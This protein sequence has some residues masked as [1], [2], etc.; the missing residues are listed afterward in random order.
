MEI[1]FRNG[2][3]GLEEYK[4]FIVETDEELQPFNILQSKDKKE[5]GLVVISPFEVMPDYEI[6]LSESVLKNL[7]ISSPDD[8]TLYTT[9]TLNS[10]VEKITANLR[11]PIVVNMKSGLGEQIIVDNDKYKI[12]HPIR[13]GGK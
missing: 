5:L 12:K 1:L 3:P 7:K 8:V 6:K 4:N 11:A 13:R 10:N 2:I 9:V